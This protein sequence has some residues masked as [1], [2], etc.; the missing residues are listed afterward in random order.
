[1]VND[2]LNSW[3]TWVAALQN[4]DPGIPEDVGL[5]EFDNFVIVRNCQLALISSSAASYA[6]GQRARENDVF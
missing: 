3:P 2:Y 6:D 5:V 1:M 4:K